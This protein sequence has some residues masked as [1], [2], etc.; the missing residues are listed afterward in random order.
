M[1]I[2]KQAL[3]LVGVTI[4][5]YLQWCSDNKFPAYRETTKKEFFKRI[6]G[7]QIVRDVKTGILINKQGDTDEE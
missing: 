3:E 7:N 5:E 2:S 6:Q 4:E 1:T